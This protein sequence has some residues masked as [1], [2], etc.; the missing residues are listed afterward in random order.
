MRLGYNGNYEPQISGRL[1]G[2]G[3][4]TKAVK[5]LWAI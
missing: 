2:I 3:I 4:L 5:G 1:S